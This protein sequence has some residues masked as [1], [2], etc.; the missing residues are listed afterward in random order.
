MFSNNSQHCWMLHVASVCTPCC[1]LLDV[2]AQSLKPIIL[3]APCKRTQHCWLTTLNIVGSCC[4][5]L[6]VALIKTDLESSGSTKISFILLTPGFLRL[7]I[8]LLVKVL[9]SITTPHE[10]DQCLCLIPHRIQYLLFR[11]LCSLH[12]FLPSSPL[13][14]WVSAILT[15]LIHKFLAT[16]SARPSFP[17]R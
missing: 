4:V 8:I 3:L 6:H 5:R 7:I 17:I 14:T 13:C 16:I 10:G 15:P 12:T 2:V 9:L 1:I 11:A